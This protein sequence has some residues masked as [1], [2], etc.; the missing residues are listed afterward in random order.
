MEMYFALA[1]RDSDPK[2]TH[3]EN[4]FNSWTQKT[5]LAAAS[6]FQYEFTDE[7]KL[8]IMFSFMF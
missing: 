1:Y 5:V 4:R 6:V 2:E 7:L 3:F 8:Q